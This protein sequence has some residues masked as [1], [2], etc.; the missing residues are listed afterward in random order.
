MPEHDP[1]ILDSEHAAFVIGNVSITT[2]SCRPGGFPALVRA[3]GCRLSV[4]RRNVTILVRA[5]AA[6]DVLDAVRRSGAIAAVFS[7]PPTHRTLQL[8]GSDALVLRPEPGDVALAERYRAAFAKVLEPFGH[9]EAMVH[10]L[11]ACAPD[12]LMTLRF[13]PTFAFSQT[14]GPRAGEALVGSA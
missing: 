8:K 11:L 2:A 4:D 5:S 12:D 6:A 1:P 9:P 13:T 3:L 14:P 10:A 7:D